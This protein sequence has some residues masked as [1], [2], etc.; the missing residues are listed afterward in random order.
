LLYNLHHTTH[1]PANIPSL[2]ITDPETGRQLPTDGFMIWVNHVAIHRNRDLWGS[3][4][5]DFK[6]ERFLSSKTEAATSKTKD[7]WR[8]FE[9]GP[10]ACIGQELALTETK[11]ILALT[12]RRFKIHTA[13]A[14]MEKVANDGLG[15]PADQ[16]GKN[17]RLMGDVAYQIIR[18]TAKPRQGMPAR[19]SLQA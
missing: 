7:A 1:L 8:P 18:A 4:V 9:K 6:P 14:D 11:I 15:W 5:N 12:L 3:D 16:G 19:V 2:F 17:G 10:R 13:Y